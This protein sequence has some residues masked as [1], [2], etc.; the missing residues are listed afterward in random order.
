MLWLL[1]ILALALVVRL[2]PLTR[3]LEQDELLAL[4]AVAERSAPAGTLPSVGQ[5]LLLVVGL[6]AVRDRSV[7]PFG[8]P[9]PYPLYNDLLYLVIKVLPITEWSL[10]LPS[11]LAGLG[12]VAGLYFLCRRTLGAEVA[13]VAG[14]LTAVDPLQVGVSTLARPY[15]LANLACVLS[16]AALLGLLNTVR[17]ATAFLAALGYGG[18]MALIGFFNPLLLF[19]LAAHIGLV[20]YALATGPRAALPRVFLWIGGCAL[21]GLFLMPELGYFRELMAFSRANPDAF[22]GRTQAGLWAFLS[23]N[24]GFLVALLVVSVVGYVVREVRTS[25]AAREAGPGSNGV[26]RGPSDTPP[27]PEAP[28]L[29]WTGRLW[30]FLPQIVALMFAQWWD[31]ALFLSRFLSY[32]T[33][34]GA[35]LLAY[36]AT[37]D[38]SR[39]ARLGL[40]LALALTLFLWSFTPLTWQG[41]GL[42]SSAAARNMVAVLDRLGEGGRW[43]P[44]DVV[45]FRPTLPEA[46]LLPDRVPPA[47][48]SQVEKALLA[49]LTTLYVPG[50]PKQAVALNQPQPVIILSRSNKFGKRAT[51]HGQHYDPER[52]YNDQLA[53]QLRGC[54]RFWLC[55]NPLE[56]DQRTF[57]DQRDYI[58]CLL[59]WLA[60][61][62]QWDLQ[63]AR[64][65]Q[66]AERYFEV[67]T[68]IKPG[69]YTAGLSD[70]RP[71]DFSPLVLIRRKQP[72]GIFSLGALGA[73]ALPYSHVTVP[74]WL[75]GQ[76][77]T[78]R[79]TEKPGIDAE[80]EPREMGTGK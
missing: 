46:D 66:G 27:L 50:Q 29:V 63:V 64:S 32:T 68:D 12:C 56:D 13:L 33:L 1:A 8:I 9:N 73:V 22:G 10:R 75:A 31:P 78:P 79:R 15:A 48:R 7:L 42:H 37:R 23:H 34:G 43:Q 60:N 59:P 74:A 40:S 57:S 54:N 49:P 77:S 19:V 80:L 6:D 35:I 67:P 47:V 52:R 55:S 28:E 18:S 2:V 53:T 16:F 14:L 62:L 65:R 17:T 70:S 61:A 69:D 26:V 71:Q 24:S 25:Q 44:G 5:P 21:A 3:P 39:D 45:L 4:A 58:A 36:W 11:L 38:R 30:L 76:S 72:K 20:V 51:R 41:R